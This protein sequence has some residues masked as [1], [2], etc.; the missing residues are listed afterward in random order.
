MLTP[1]RIDALAELAG[2]CRHRW[3]ERKIT[4]EMMHAEMNT[5]A[6]NL[7]TRWYCPDCGLTCCDAAYQQAQRDKD[8]WYVALGECCRETL[9]A[10]Y[11]IPAVGDGTWQPTLE[12]LFG[13]IEVRWDFVQIERI[14]RTWTVTIKVPF[15]EEAGREV[16]FG[17]ALSHSLKGALA[18]A[19]LEASA[20]SC[21]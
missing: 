12:A 21:K 3:L 10:L 6:M 20:V 5:G 18:E 16:I 4:K 2:E 1:K 15:G 13:I 7:A 17:K 19:I 8:G 14:S 11:D 9:G